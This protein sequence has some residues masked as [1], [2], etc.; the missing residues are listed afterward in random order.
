MKLQDDMS[1]DLPDSHEADEEE[2]KSDHA[3]FVAAK[4]NEVAT[5]TATIETNLGR[6]TSVS[7]WISQD[8]RLASCCAPLASKLVVNAKECSV[9]QELTGVTKKKG[10]NVCVRCSKKILERPLAWIGV[11]CINSAPGACVA[12]T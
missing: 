9:R 8:V 10:T 3:T 2:R 6:V 4:E 7:R 12:A 11:L 1:A 5:S